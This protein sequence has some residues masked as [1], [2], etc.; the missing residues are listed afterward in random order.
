MGRP[1]QLW[2]P[3]TEMRGNCDPGLTFPQSIA[4]LSQEGDHN[5]LIM[6][7][8]SVWPTARKH[9]KC[10]LES[11][12]FRL[13]PIYRKPHML[14]LAFLLPSQAGALEDWLQACF[15][16]SDLNGRP[17]GFGWFCLDFFPLLWCVLTLH[18]FPSFSSSLQLFVFICT[19]WGTSTSPCETFIQ[20]VF[21]QDKRNT[22]RQFNAI[23]KYL[24]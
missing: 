22:T 10:P 18:A 1:Q 6:G 23:L 15:F 21:P 3:C 16:G 7:L 2:P 9:W 13:L 11:I 14:T 12:C 20:K 17:T 8:W 19:S 24:L 5:S 4:Q